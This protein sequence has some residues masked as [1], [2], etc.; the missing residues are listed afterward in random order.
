M[1]HEVPFKPS[2]PPKRGYNKTLDKFPP[3]VP[4][5]MKVTVRKKT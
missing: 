5:P 3:Y 4:D 1:T 2:N